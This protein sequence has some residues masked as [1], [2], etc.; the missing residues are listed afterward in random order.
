[1]ETASSNYGSDRYGLVWGYVLGAGKEAVSIDSDGAA[2]WLATAASTEPDRFVW[3][4][5][6]LANAACRSWLRANLKLPDAFH[7]ELREG[8][9]STRLER[10]GDAL[11][12]VVHDV[13]FD[14]T[15][16]AS[17]VSTVSLCVQPQV[18]VSAR[19]KPLRSLDRLRASVK[20][21]DGFASPAGLLAQL[22]RDQAGVLA[23]ILRQ[24]TGRVDEIED[25]MLT[26]RIAVSRMELGALRRVLVRLQR[27]LAPEPAA[28]FR[29]LS[30]P[31]AWIGA[32]D[33]QDLRE[34]AEEF[35]VAVTDSAALGER[36]KLLQEELA[37]TVSERTGR[38]LFVLT[39]VTVLALPINLAAGLLG[40]NVGGIPFADDRGGFW[41]ILMS[42]V[43][44]TAVV[45]YLALKKSR[46]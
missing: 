46:D 15:F 20:S 32:E 23:D 36:V 41:T 19:L 37:A 1:M 22:L 4:H 29:L 27:L 28:L 43:G 21:G 11:L 17:D 38:T 45:G 24:T 10:D 8:T 42:L 12:A 44:F 40:M 5:F 13:L 33:V 3:L 16:D 35:S 39:V 31:P 26:N 25:R 18:M 34:A 9:G 30:R 7:D 6:S 14:F 2:K